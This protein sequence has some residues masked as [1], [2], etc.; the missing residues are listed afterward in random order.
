MALVAAAAFNGNCSKSDS[1]SVAAVTGSDSIL[2]DIDFS[3][4]SEAADSSVSLAGP[5]D[6]KKRPPANEDI[7]LNMGQ[8]VDHQISGV[9][10]LMER[11]KKDGVDAEGDY[12]DL[13]P[14]KKISITVKAAED[15]S[16]DHQAVICYD[17]NV[18]TFTQFK[19]DGSAINLTLDQQYQPIGDGPDASTAVAKISFT[20]DGTKKTLVHEMTGQPRRIPR[21]IDDDESYLTEKI[22]ATIDADEN[23]SIAVVGDWHTEDATT[24]VAD[25]YLLGQLEK[26]GDKH[27]GKSVGFR[28]NKD[29]CGATF[30]EDAPKASFCLGRVVGSD[31]GYTD[32]QRDA[33]YDELETIG[34]LKS[35]ELEAVAMPT[36]L[37]CP[38]KP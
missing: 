19:E 33:A 20:D 17:G 7:L 37:T 29:D 22:K 8:R 25:S 2:P 24:Y 34:L 16:F 5:L 31:T 23:F 15:E 36:G 12:F 11:L 1:D 3:V 35:S 38:T 32:E 21:G 9:T 14:D 28:A 6:N 26:D 4:P 27:V 30:D 10:M 18:F 13:G